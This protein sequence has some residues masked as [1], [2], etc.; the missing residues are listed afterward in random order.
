MHCI[1]VKWRNWKK[2]QFSLTHVVFEKLYSKKRQW[3]TQ[4]MLKANLPFVLTRTKTYPR[5]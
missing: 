2:D 1:M 4:T 3:N 5:I